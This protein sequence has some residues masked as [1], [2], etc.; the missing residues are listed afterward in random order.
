MGEVFLK[1]KKRLDIILHDFKIDLKYFS[2]NLAL[3]RFINGISYRGKFLK[4]INK[5][6]L[7]KKDQ[8]ILKYLAKNY[9]YIIDKYKNK[10]ETAIYSE[11]QNIWICW[12]QGEESAP[13]LVKNCINSVRR[14]ANGHKVIIIT[15]DNFKDYVDIPDYILEKYEKGII[16][17]AHFS[18]IMRMSLICKHGGIWID[19]TVFC[20]KKL[21]D[22]IFNQLFFTCKSPVAET[23]YISNLQW[24]SFIIGGQKNSLFFR[25]NLEFYLEYWKKEEQLIDY[26]FIDYVIYLGYQNIMKIKYAMDA[27]K[28]NNTKRDELYSIFNEEFS[29]KIYQELLDS[30]TYLYKLSWREAF[31]HNTIEGKPTF[32]NVFLNKYDDIFTSQGVKL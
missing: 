18:D 7:N 25:F 9:G 28:I 17:H 14:N 29:L 10:E 24:T 4:Q 26:L 23:D 15:K 6:S 3:I 19:A 30:D 1:I 27:N 8:C 31:R 11:K 5:W 32:Y 22:K 16:S 2:F 21:P 12:L 13:Q 20:T